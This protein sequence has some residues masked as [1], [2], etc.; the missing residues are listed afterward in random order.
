MTEADI[1]LAQIDE[2]CRRLRIAQSTFGR[3]AV[4]D[5]K[6]VARLQQGGRV[7]LQTVDRVHRFIGEQGG[8]SA[9]SL[10]TLIR[11]SHDTPPGHDFR[12]YDNRQK[13]LMFVNTSSEKQ[14]IADRALE[15]LTLTQ[16][17]PPAIRLFDGGTGDGTAFARLLRGA[18]RRYPWLPF[19]VVAKEISIEN[20]R[21]MLEK[22]PDRF[23]E[24]PAT[25]LVVTNLPYAEAPWLRPVSPAAAERMVWHEMALEGSTAGDFEEAIAGLQPFLEQN[26]QVDVSG[27]TG[28]PVIKNPAVLV[29]YRRDNQ[30]VLDSVLPRRGLARADFDF[31][32][33][34]HAYR[35]RMPLRYKAQAIV[36]PLVRALRPSGRLMGVQAYGEDPGME[37]IRAIW[38]GENPFDGRRDALMDAVEDA[39]GPAAHAFRFHD[40]SDAQSLFRYHIRT[41]STEIDPRAE[42]GT[43][44]LFAA[45]NAASY[46]AQIEDRRLGAAMNRDEYL[47]VTRAALR[48]HAGLW[49]T[50]ETYLVSRRAELG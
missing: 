45:W 29:I 19:Y 2:A 3:L 32:L 44:T 4:N 31:V 50:N 35:A 15:Q 38:P 27:R 1:L 42:I 14:M 46:V 9:A 33:L 24:H 37:I 21:L 13:Y 10:R 48:R 12:F 20:V 18:H 49:F 5:G 16:P 7:T 47:E 25:V 8:P 6:F 36:A 22:M 28:H 26:W 39:L 11:G 40:L 41:L 30:F 34:S 43:S 23:Q 17:Q